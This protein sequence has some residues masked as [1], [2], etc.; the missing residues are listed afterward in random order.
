MPLH[1]GANIIT[2]AQI[3]ASNGVLMSPQPLV[4][5]PSL[6]VARAALPTSTPRGRPKPDPCNVAT[7]PSPL[8]H[9]KRRGRGSFAGASP[10][11]AIDGDEDAITDPEDPDQ[12]VLE[13]S[14]K[15]NGGDRGDSS[16]QFE[17]EE[18]EK[19][20][21]GEEVGERVG[22]KVGEDRRELKEK[23]IDHGDISF[24]IEDLSSGSEDEEESAP[25]NKA[26]SNPPPTTTT[27]TSRGASNG[28][29]VP[30][31]GA[32]VLLPQQQYA[33]PNVFLPGN[34]LYQVVVPA[35][36][37]SNGAVESGQIMSVQQL[38]NQVKVEPYHQVKLVSVDAVNPVIGK[39]KIKQG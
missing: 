24:E 38:F 8:E 22:G 14:L 23:G 12:S 35:G 28:G 13:T 37:H 26:P 27:T 19:E 2:T 4:M 34:R 29:I 5:A 36:V 3:P 25:K 33:V 32:T 39:E 21:E 1:A 18:E 10:K 17:D 11:V 20:G 15:E 16:S 7:L 31:P 6:H 9:S 30:S